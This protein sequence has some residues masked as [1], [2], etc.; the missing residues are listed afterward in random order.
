MGVTEPATKLLDLSPRRV[1]LASPYSHD[2]IKVRTSRFR[3]VTRLAGA[4]IREGHFVFSPIS[5]GHPIAIHGNTP[6]DYAYWSGFNDSVLNWANHFVIYKIEGWK[7]SIGIQH[8]T[9]IALEKNLPIT[10]IEPGWRK[11]RR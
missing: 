4:L 10:T 6:G 7:E 3:A 8:E 2:D 5:H 11:V 9:E 1:Y